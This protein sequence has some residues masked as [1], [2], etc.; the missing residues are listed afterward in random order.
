MT[1]IRYRLLL[2]FSLIIEGFAYLVGFRLGLPVKAALML[3]RWRAN[4]RRK[5]RPDDDELVDQV[6]HDRLA[7]TDADGVGER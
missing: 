1:S 6:N 7:A 2:G 3:A 4:E 5:D